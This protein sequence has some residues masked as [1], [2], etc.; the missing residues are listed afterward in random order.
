MRIGEAASAAGVEASAIRFYEQRGV[1]PPSVRTQSGYRAYD[2][3]D[4][5]LIRFVRLARGVGLPLADVREMVELRTAG[6]P[7][8]PVVREAI[9]REIN[10][11]E[12]RIGDLDDTRVE[13]TRLSRLLEETSGDW[14][15]GAR[16]CHI[17]EG[18][19]AE[20]S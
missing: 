14:P 20:L 19:A 16:V 5:E 17:V 8:C 2:D 15:D 13:L 3:D 9:T 10:T 1:L 11:I 12:A 7:P 18:S 4:V 6:S